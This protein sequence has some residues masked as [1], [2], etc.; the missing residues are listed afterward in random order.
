MNAALARHLWESPEVR[1]ALKTEAARL[2]WF[3]VPYVGGV[4]LSRYLREQPLF[5][6]VLAAVIGAVAVALMWL[7]SAVRTLRA[8][9][10]EHDPCAVNDDV[11][12]K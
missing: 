7:V 10:R 4:A 9:L 2:L 12:R 6:G 11:G 3:V 8:V 5:E 1:N